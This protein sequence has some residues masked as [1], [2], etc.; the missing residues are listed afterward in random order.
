MTI[1]EQ[2]MNNTRKYGLAS[3]CVSSFLQII[4]PKIEEVRTCKRN[5]NIYIYIYMSRSLNFE[6]IKKTNE[7]G[8]LEFAK[9]TYGFLLA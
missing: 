4:N 8:Q 2:N 6:E 3:S 1:Y 7:K 9:N 5:N